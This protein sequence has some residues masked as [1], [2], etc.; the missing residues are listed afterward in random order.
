MIE[1]STVLYLNKENLSTKKI[2]FVDELFQ[3]VKFI[4]YNN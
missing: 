3:I 2:N 4:D 1:K